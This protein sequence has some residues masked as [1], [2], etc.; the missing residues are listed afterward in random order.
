MNRP[1]ALLLTV[2][3]LSVPEFAAAQPARGRPAPRVA[4]DPSARSHR[5]LRARLRDAKSAADAE[6][7]LEAIEKALPAST[8]LGPANAAPPSS[9]YDRNPEAVYQAANAPRRAYLDRQLWADAAER[10]L[11][12]QLEA[13]PA[14]FQEVADQ[15]RKRLPDRP[16]V[17]DRLLAK[18]VEAAAKDVTALRQADVEKLA[19]VYRKDGGAAGEQKARDLYRGW[20]DHQREHLLGPSDAE[21]RIVLAGQYRSLLNDTATAAK[22]LQEA[23]AIDPQAQG[24][25]N[26]L[27]NLGYKKVG[28]RWYAPGQAAEIPPE[29]AAPPP[30]SEPAGSLIGMTRDDVRRKLGT[31]DRASRCATQGQIVEQWTYRG[32]R[33][34][35][36]VDFAHRGRGVPTVI[37]QG[38]LP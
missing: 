16:K 25:A 21:T 38:A 15:A 28:E 30:K 24:A 36:Y 7:L 11:E 12:L 14:D 29:P 37:F 32:N 34:T 31:P 23:L 4:S 27:A 33:G 1:L 22:L 2:A 9:A 3:A 5:A 6:A 10:A 26:S 17:A 35:Q 8:T 13:N 18:G 20:L 19:K